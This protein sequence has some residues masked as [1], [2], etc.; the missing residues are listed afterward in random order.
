MILQKWVK[1]LTWENSP[2]EILGRFQHLLRLQTFFYNAKKM[3]CNTAK[4]NDIRIFRRHS[5]QFSTSHSAVNDRFLWCYKVIGRAEAGGR[6]ILS[7]V[8]SSIEH[9]RCRE[10]QRTIFEKKAVFI[11]FF[12]P[13]INLFHWCHSVIDERNTT[14]SDWKSNIQSDEI[15]EKS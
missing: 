14:G 7:E 1:M 15:F 6:V 2:P 12:G 13:I 4:R 9:L 8:W 11:I 5:R 3:K 10:S